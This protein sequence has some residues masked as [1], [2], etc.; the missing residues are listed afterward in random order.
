M[1]WSFSPR[2]AQNNVSVVVVKEGGSSNGPIRTCRRIIIR[3]S[4]IQWWIITP[5]GKFWI[6]RPGGTTK[7]SADGFQRCAHILK[8][9]ACTLRLARGQDSLGLQNFLH[10]L[11]RPDHDIRARSRHRLRDKVRK[12]DI[13]VLLAFLLPQAHA[14]R[15]H[16]LTSGGWAHFLLID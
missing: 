12:L 13:M 9:I 14:P 10:L 1:H 4:E 11:G 16:T 7:H 2:G 15:P 5:K 6:L 3:D 8:A